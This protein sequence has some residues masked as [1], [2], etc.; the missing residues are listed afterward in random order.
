MLRRVFELP[1]LAKGLLLVVFGAA[2]ELAITAKSATGLAEVRQTYSTAINQEAESAFALALASR[3]GQGVARQ[4]LRL[5]DATDA[6][7]RAQIATRIEQLFGGAQ[8]A[9]REAEAAYPGLREALRAPQ[10]DLE[11]LRGLFGELRGLAERDQAAAETAVRQQFDPVADRLR[12]SLDGLVAQRR[13]ALS[14]SEVAAENTASATLRGVLMVSAGALIAGIALSLVLFHYGVGRPMRALA[15]EVDR[16]AGGGLDS[17]V[18]GAARRDEVGA[19]ARSL[20]T[21]RLE[22]LEKRRIELRA[23]EELA[24]KDRIQR[25]VDHH[26][27][28]FGTSCSSVM[29]EVIRAAEEMGSLAK[30]NAGRTQE[31]HQRAEETGR[32]ASESAANLVTVAGATEELVASVQE[33]ARQAGEVT[34]AVT[35]AVEEARTSDQMVTGLVSAAA[36]IGEVVRLI[37]DIAGRTNL[38]AL[39]ATIE[40]ARA[41]EAGKGFAVVA[42]EVKN[43]AAQTAKAT[44]DIAGRIAAVQGA[45]DKASGAIARIGTTIGGV[46]DIA[47]AIQSAVEQQ[48]AAT[49]EIAATVQTVSQATEAT[50]QAMADVTRLSGETGDA[51]GAVA[52]AA[53]QVGAQARTMQAELE[54]FLVAMRDSAQRRRYERHACAD[55]TATIRRGE[56]SRS[57]PIADLSRGGVAVRASLGWEAGSRVTISLRGARAP[58]EARLVRETDGRAAFAFR[59]DPAALALVDQALDA[60]L[61]ARAAA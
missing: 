52:A 48:S 8:N 5:P 1:I 57:V 25:A 49:R 4:M 36:E 35:R 58:I 6:A 12:D 45:T 15:A 11:T 21:F 43:L 59:Q 10:R 37:E 51:S 26:V 47:G 18:A 17:P 7:E 2:A 9:L 53:G 3:Y 16:V 22:G 29:G 28:E 14:A 34:Q 60:I 44:A 55:E 32:A 61:G 33:I 38:L 19:L 31:N 46:A 39:N 41:G 42:S 50:R 23:A 54:A 20:D 56:A 40:A 13:A 30:G 27:Q 24:T